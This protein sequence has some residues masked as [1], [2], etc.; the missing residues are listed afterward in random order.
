M[1]NRNL[2]A[3][4]YRGR[5]ITASKYTFVSGFRARCR[6]RLYDKAPS[7]SQPAAKAIPRIATWIRRNTAATKPPA[8]NNPHAMASSLAW[9]PRGRDRRWRSEE[10]T[11]ELQSRENLVCRLLL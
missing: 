4:W 5:K 3:Q 1:A 2:W 6:I 7:R 9:G 10:H 11:S 8:E